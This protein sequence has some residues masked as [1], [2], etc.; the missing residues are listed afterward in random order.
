MRLLLSDITHIIKR[1]EERPGNDKTGPEYV[2]YNI[3]NEGEFIDYLYS[4]GARQV[5]IVPDELNVILER[6]HPTSTYTYGDLQINGNIV[7]TWK[8]VRVFK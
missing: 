1:Y 4:L 7:M 3:W 8:W 5:D 6:T 2:Y